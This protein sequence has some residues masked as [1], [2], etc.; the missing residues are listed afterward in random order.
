MGRSRSRTPF[1]SLSS[2]SAR[3]FALMA[4]DTSDSRSSS[5]ANARSTRERSAELDGECHQH[6]GSSADNG[7]WS[8]TATALGR[9]NGQPHR[10][11]AREPNRACRCEADERGCRR[12]AGCSAGMVWGDRLTGSLRDFPVEAQEVA[13]HGSEDATSVPARS[14]PSGWRVCQQLV[15][16]VSARWPWPARPVTRRRTTYG[17]RERENTKREKV[18]A[19]SDRRVARQAS[20]LDGDPEASPEASESELIEQLAGLHRAFD[21]GDVELD[22]LEE[23]Q[24]LIREQLARIHR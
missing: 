16:P 11:S 19:K 3:T 4:S 9:G 20:A 1:S 24:E 10:V 8:A 18:K 17:K 2:S 22:E 23:Q 15:F 7:R 12:C 6:V 21:A 14:A 5:I 13:P